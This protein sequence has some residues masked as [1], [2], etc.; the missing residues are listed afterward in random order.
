[1][2]GGSAKEDMESSPPIHAGV[3]FVGKLIVSRWAEAYTYSDKNLT[4]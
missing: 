1:M 2:D 3:T 4:V